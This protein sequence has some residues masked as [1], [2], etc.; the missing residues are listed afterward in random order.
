MLT[1]GT[2]HSSHPNDDS[3]LT[4]QAHPTLLRVKD[5]TKPQ[6][7]RITAL[8]K[9]LEDITEEANSNE[10]IELAGFSTLAR[11]IELNTSLL[12]SI[13]SIN[14]PKP[15]PP[16]S[17]S[18]PSTKSTKPEDSKNPHKIPP[19]ISISP[20]RASQIT[21]TLPPLPLILS[22]TLEAAVFTHSGVTSSP[23]ASYERLEWIG[24]AYVEL[25][26]TLLIAQTFTTYPPGKCATIR[27]SL[28]KNASLAAYARNYDF[29]SR[30]RLP[31]EFATATNSSNDGAVLGMPKQP[32]QDRNKVMGDI[33]EAYVAGVVLSDAEHGVARVAEWLK[34][35][36]AP[37]LKVQIADY[38]MQHV[39]AGAE[40][41][42][43]KEQLHAALQ[44]KDVK[45]TYRECAPEKKD[46]ETGAPLFSVGVY[47]DGWGMSDH[48]LGW[49][50]AR[51]KKE[52]GAK[53]ARMALE[54]RKLLGRL[55]SLKAKADEER[56][57]IRAVEEA[58]GGAGATAES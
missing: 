57:A 29:H 19:Y 10:L 22:P 3:T 23:N 43:A 2:T 5:T 51:G 30:A 39:R 7:E 45:L 47:L 52:A 25:T 54:N 33:F 44:G 37:Q 42:S 28:V 26:A 55:G 49:G 24:D 35:L 20:W 12:S 31:P 4:S 38:E 46:R 41:L 50:V 53:A 14:S 16:V 56:A 48:S 58:A 18:G 1:N 36:W 27:E 21:S 17:S 34:C 15:R 6:S 8:L 32:R 40:R 9:A 11:C 13:A